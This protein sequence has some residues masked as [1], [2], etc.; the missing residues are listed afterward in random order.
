MVPYSFLNGASGSKYHI[1]RSHQRLQIAQPNKKSPQHFQFYFIFLRSF[2]N[3]YKIDWQLFGKTHTQENLSFFFFFKFNPNRI[4]TI[5]L[6]Y[7]RFPPDLFHSKSYVVGSCIYGKDEHPCIVAI[8]MV[9]LN[10][11][12]LFH[13][14]GNYEHPYIVTIK[15]LTMNILT[16]LP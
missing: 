11:L 14:N 13:K 9:T 8:K 1:K 15:M 4:D 12:T 5:L 3:S 7:T 10:I 16:L 2:Q 6:R